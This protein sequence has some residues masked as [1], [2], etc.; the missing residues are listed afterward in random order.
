MCGSAVLL[1]L[2]TLIDIFIPVADLT[3]VQ[4][5]Y[6]KVRHNGERHADNNII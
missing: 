6:S 5:S 2:G 1:H 4:S 3:R